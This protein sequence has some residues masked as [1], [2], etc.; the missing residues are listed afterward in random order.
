[1]YAEAAR[2]LNPILYERVAQGMFGFR[3]RQ[4]SALYYQ[5]VF[6]SFVHGTLSIG[7][8]LVGLKKLEGDNQWKRT[9]RDQLYHPPRPG[10]K[11]IL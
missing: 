8:S 4:V 6:A 9:G 5:T 10:G 11:N 2:L 3:L 1:V 7:A